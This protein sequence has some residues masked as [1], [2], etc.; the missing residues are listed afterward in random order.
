[1]GQCKKANKELKWYTTIDFNDGINQ[2]LKNIKHWKNAPVWTVKKI[3][4]A[5][6]TCLTIKKMINK[7]LTDEKLKILKSKKEK[8]LCVMEYLI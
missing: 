7:L 5:T 2:L 1:M 6:K 8:F 3:N 4:I